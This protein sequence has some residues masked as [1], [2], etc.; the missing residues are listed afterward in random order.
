MQQITDA[1]KRMKY[2]I[3]NGTFEFGDNAFI[4]R[5]L[6]EEYKAKYQYANKGDILISA[7][8]SIV[9]TLCLREKMSIFKTPI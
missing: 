6:F 2:H 4:S 1:G 3:K 9:G 5:E 7:S 8:G